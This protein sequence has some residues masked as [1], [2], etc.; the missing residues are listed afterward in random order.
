MAL[1]RGLHI[2][3]EDE[4]ADALKRVSAERAQSIGELV[5]QAIRRTYLVGLQGIS[6]R[7]AEA[8]AAFEGGFISLGRLSEELGMDAVSLRRWLH[9]NG[10][11]S[12][13]VFSRSD[14]EH[15]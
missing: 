14:I 1:N 5:R 12:G 3:I 10:R 2:K 7:Q 6:A 9:E 15:V 4:L 11:D 13:E 8:M